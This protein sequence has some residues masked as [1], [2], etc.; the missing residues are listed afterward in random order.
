MELIKCHKTLFTIYTCW[1]FPSTPKC[2]LR[3]VNVVSL[4]PFVPCGGKVS[5]QINRMGFGSG[6]CHH[7][8][9]RTQWQYDGYHDDWQWPQQPAIKYM[10]V[11]VLTCFVCVCVVNWSRGDNLISTGCDKEKS[12]WITDGSI[13]SFSLHMHNEKSLVFHSLW[14]QTW[15]KETQTFQQRLQSS[16]AFS[17]DVIISKQDPD[18]MV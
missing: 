15:W 7:P 14:W 18:Q 9:K 16:S 2:W 10:P 4:S 5:W 12:K 11:L 3:S 1:K 17:T 6:M 8:E 13:Q